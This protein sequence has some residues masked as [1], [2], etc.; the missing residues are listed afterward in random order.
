MEVKDHLTG[1]VLKVYTIYVSVLY[2]H[3]H[4]VHYILLLLFNSLHSIEELLA[5]CFF[6]ASLC[7]SCE[8]TQTSHTHTQAIC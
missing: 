2:G 3:K 4:T 8:N 7:C 5:L 6:S 1:P